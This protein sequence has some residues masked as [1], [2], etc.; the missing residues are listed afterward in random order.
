MEFQAWVDSVGGFAAAASRLGVGHKVVYLWYT[1]R[2]H[3]KVDNI[4]AIMRETGMTAD[5][6]LASTHK[7]F[8]RLTKRGR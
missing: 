4:L 2:Q 1:R 3:P 5:Q 7:D 8:K 6:V